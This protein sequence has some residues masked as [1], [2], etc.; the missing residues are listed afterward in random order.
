MS[1]KLSRRKSSALKVLQEKAVPVRP[2]VAQAWELAAQRLIARLHHLADPAV[3][4]LSSNGITIRSLGRKGAGPGE[5]EQPTKA[6][7]W[8][9]N[10][11]L[12]VDRRLSRMLV[13]DST[14]KATGVLAFPPGLTEGG[15]QFA[16]GTDPQGRIL[17]QT[18]WLGPDLRKPTQ[19]VYL[20]RWDP[21]SGRVDTVTALRPPEVKQTRAG[22]GAETTII[23]QVMPFAPQDDWAVGPDGSVVV[24]RVQDFRVEWHRN[25]QPALLGLPLSVQPVRVSIG[26]KQDFEP[27]GPPFELTYPPTKPPFPAGGILVAP[28]GN[29]WI[30]LER[31]AAQPTRSY[32]VIDRT[33]RRTETV[34]VGA[35]RWIVAFGK[36]TCYV[37]WSDDEDEHWLEAYRR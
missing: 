28:E 18:T 21:S 25:S 34:R 12:I 33:G 10:R 17:M 19:G 5:F 16:R 26:D 23:R 20:V 4:V 13:L 14:L 24:V 22:R 29:V 6:L 37:V 9:K 32:L 36:R 2:T 8:S 27:K 15:A 1:S 30:E 11:V 3:R 35:R 7:Q 31:P